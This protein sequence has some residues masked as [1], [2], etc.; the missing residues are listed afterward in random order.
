MCI[1]LYNL[2]MNKYNIM[3]LQKYSGTY[4]VCTLLYVAGTRDSVLIREVP[5]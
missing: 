3:F 1:G 5:L 2:V 4:L